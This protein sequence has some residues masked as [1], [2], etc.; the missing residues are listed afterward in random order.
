MS[1]WPLNDLVLHYLFLNVI[2]PFLTRTVNYIAG[3]GI[4]YRIVKN[5]NDPYIP[6]Y[7]P[8]IPSQ[9]DPEFVNAG[10]KYGAGS[11]PA[12]VA[13]DVFKGTVFY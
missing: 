12:A 6:P 7:F 2:S 5:S 9:Y 3:P 10:S 13:D 11:P 1:F 8:T 4:G